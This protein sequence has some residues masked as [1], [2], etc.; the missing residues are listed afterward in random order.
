MTFNQTLFVT[1]LDKAIIG[2]L[3]LVAGFWLNRSIELF[4]SQLEF[5]KQTAVAREAAYRR[6]WALTQ[7]FSPSIRTDL[8]TEHRDEVALSLRS[9]YY[10]DGNGIYLSRTAADL[11][12]KARDLLKQPD[13]DADRIRHAFSALRTQMKLDVGVYDTADAQTQ[14]GLR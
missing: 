14:I 9:W 8:P 5:R 11:F 4:K 10:T 7:I 6:L 1:V 12:F 2:G 3:L 13:E